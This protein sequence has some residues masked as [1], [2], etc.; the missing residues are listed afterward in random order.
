MRS[1]TQ[2]Y[3]HVID[4]DISL[5]V[6]VVAIRRLNNV[7]YALLG[8]AAAVGL[9]KLNLEYGHLRS[10]AYDTRCE[11]VG[12]YGNDGPRG[13]EPKR[14]GP[15]RGRNSIH[16]G[17]EDRIL[18][19]KQKHPSWGARRIKHQYDLPCH[20][21]TVHRV[22][23]RYGM[24]VRIKPKPQPYKRFQRRHVDSMWQGDTFQFRIKGVG[25]VYLTGFTDD[26]SRYRVASGAYLY[27]GAKEA[28]D[29]CATPSGGRGFRG[30]FILTMRSSSS[31]MS[32]GKRRANMGSS[33]SSQG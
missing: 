15:V 22:I 10:R 25:K 16:R 11:S 27:K 6:G 1:H 17:L 13:L 2:R 12:A 32:S 33:S 26:R 20:W 19:L 14:P 7:V 24:L 8:V 31:P 21:R 4:L 9:P 29:A 30:G 23:K 18:S 3:V 28:V 5:D